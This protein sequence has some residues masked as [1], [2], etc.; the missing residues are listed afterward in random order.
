MTMV[1]VRRRRREGKDFRS[2]RSVAREKV[3]LGSSRAREEGR[4]GEWRRPDRR[5]GPCGWY[6]FECRNASSGSHA[7]PPSQP[8]RGEVCGT[9]S[10]SGD[11]RCIH[12]PPYERPKW[13]RLHYPRLRRRVA[14][15]RLNHPLPLPSL[16]LPHLREGESERDCEHSSPPPRRF[17]GASPAF[18]T[19]R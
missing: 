11:G 13:L 4:G 12:P 1:R 8:S 18:C 5:D 7:Q 3:A 15:R 6:R 9:G 14:R 16:P 2:L 17:R 19:T 10:G